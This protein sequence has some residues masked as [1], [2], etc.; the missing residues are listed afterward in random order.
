[1]AKSRCSRHIIP[2]ERASALR[3]FEEGLRQVP[4]ERY[5]VERM[6]WH[7]RIKDPQ[8]PLRRGRVS[9]GCRWDSNATVGAAR[10]ALAGAPAEEGPWLTLIAVQARRVFEE[11]LQK[12]QR[13]YAPAED[14]MVEAQ[15]Q[16]ATGQLVVVA[17]YKLY[18]DGRIECF[19]ILDEV[20]WPTG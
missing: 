20:L 4:R 17:R 16:D 15:A 3:A 18:V 1:M 19:E 9:L 10:R 8:G 13:Q 11:T 5:D 12:V 6:R 7:C 2:A 14:F